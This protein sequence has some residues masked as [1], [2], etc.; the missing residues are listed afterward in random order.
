[1]YTA[2]LVA[3][4]KYTYTAYLV[5]IDIKVI[6]TAYLV[7]TDIRVHLYCLISCHGHQSTFIMPT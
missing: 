3:M 7:A 6:Y 2:Y 1:M 4:D 5:A